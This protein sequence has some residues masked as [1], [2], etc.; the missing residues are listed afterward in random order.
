MSL[1]AKRSNLVACISGNA[2]AIPHVRDFTRSS[3]AMTN[4]RLFIEMPYYQ[5]GQLHANPF[6]RFVGGC[7]DMW[8]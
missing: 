8:R 1:R 6:L 4:G 7:A 2:L 5:T 3:F